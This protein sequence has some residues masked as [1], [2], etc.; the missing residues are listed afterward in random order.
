MKYTFKSELAPQIRLFIEYKHSLGYKYERGEYYLSTLDRFYAQNNFGAKLSKDF[1][2]SWIMARE[3][4]NPSPYRSWLSPVREFGRYLQNVG[5]PDAYVVSDKFTIRDYKPIPY[6]FTEAEIISFFATCDSTLLRKH[7]QLN[8]RHLILP[9]LFRFLY[10]CGVR[11]CEARF[12]LRENVEL[13]KGYVDIL[14]SKGLKDRR[15]YLSDELLELFEKFNTKISKHL[16]S[17]HYFFPS[18]SCNCFSQPM[19]AW[20]F[21]KI[22]DAA[23]LRNDAIKQPRAY[24]FR[25]HFAFS[26]I[27]RWIKEGKNVNA[28]LPYLMRYMG[29]SSLEST[30]Y[31]THLVPEFFSTYVEK[32]KSL[33]SIIPEISHGQK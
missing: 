18:D 22:W 30:F 28:M 2:E 33:E 25:H 11:T 23:G 7:L 13:K 29:H 10:C 3:D 31:Y 15:L 17:R 32:T 6:F 12:L 4:A 9:V 5:Y 1:V 16:P 21:N 24:D 20:N 14:S 19:I 27:N 26:N 8:G